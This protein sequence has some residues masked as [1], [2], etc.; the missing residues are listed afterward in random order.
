LDAKRAA[1]KEFSMVKAQTY[2]KAG[3]TKKLVLLN[4]SLSDDSTMFL[5]GLTWQTVS[6]GLY[7]CRY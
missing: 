6:L 4:V 7:Q 1:G 3:K 5:D 2:L